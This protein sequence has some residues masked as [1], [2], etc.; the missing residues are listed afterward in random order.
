MWSGNFSD[1]AACVSLQCVCLCPSPCALPPWFCASVPST[2]PLGVSLLSLPSV[3]LSVCHISELS[4]PSFHFLRPL[5]V[6]PARSPVRCYF[7]GCT[8]VFPS[9][10]TD[11][12]GSAREVLSGACAVTGAGTCQTSFPSV[13]RHCR[14]DTF[15]C[16]CFLPVGWAPTL[17]LTGRCS[18]VA[19]CSLAVPARPLRASDVTSG[20]TFM[21]LLQTQCLSLSVPASLSLCMAASISELG[22][23]LHMPISLSGFAS[24][25]ACASL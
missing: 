11:G 14:W 18:D 22:L 3:C 24:V 6:P 17:V 12:P 2:I 1:S 15:C 8:Q 23:C 9:P 4:C 10:V 20:S 13:P 5:A 21:C 7:Q 16:F 19:A 25:S